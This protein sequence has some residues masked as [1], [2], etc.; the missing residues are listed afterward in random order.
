MNL[1][2]TGAAAVIIS[3]IFF[4][5]TTAVA[6]A[7]TTRPFDGAGV[8]RLSTIDGA[9]PS[10]FRQAPNEIIVRY[11]DSV[12]LA[13]RTALHKKLGSTVV[14]DFSHIGAMER[15]RI[16]RGM[17]VQ[18]A[19][20]HFV[21]SPD[22]LYA[23]PNYIV[24][25]HRIPDDPLFIYQWGL[26]NTG[27]LGGYAGADIKAATA[28]DL[29]TGSDNAVVAVIDTGV[30][31]THPDLAG[32][33]FRNLADCA[34]DG[35]DSDGNGYIDDCHGINT[36][37]GVSDPMDYIGHG[38]VI[39]GIIGAVGN[40]AT[41]ITGV[42][43]TTRILPCRFFDDSGYGTTADAI[44]CL[45]Y[46]AEMKDRGVNIVASNNSWG[47]T[48]YS[49]ALHDAIASHLERGILFITSAGNDGMNN[50]SLMPYPCSYDLPNIICVAMTD[51]YD[52]LSVDSNF[53]KGVVHLAA[54]GVDI[55]SA[56]PGENYAILTGTSAAVPFVSGVA[57]LIR[58]Y[59]PGLD[60]RGV[61]NR[62][63]AGGDARTSLAAT[64]VTG[65]RLNANGALTCS[66]ST[67]LR[68]L[69]PIESIL[70]TG[71]YPIELSALHINCAHPN[72][73]VHVSISPTGETVTL[74]DNGRD[75]D[76]VAGDGIYSGSWQPPFSGTFTLSYPD[77]ATVTVEADTDLQ[78]GF[79]VK[80]WHSYRETSPGPGI[81]TLV[82]N[83]NGE[84][85]F[86]IFAASLGWGPLNG[87][88]GRG[89]IL[90]GWPVD[91]LEMP[92]AAAGE[93]SA[94]DPGNEIVISI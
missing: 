92:F 33:M 87:W 37:N 93:L 19:V 38:T 58:G 54:P 41:G 20:S 89:N 49:M 8:R 3:V 76:L 40:N 86:Q 66:N 22:V 6:E 29:A 34:I 7:P 68:K 73:E 21:K 47:G 27:S 13:A 30:D 82:A 85:G 45:D 17:L 44:E 53:G 31:Y 26:H 56:Y 1:R 32:N 63:L 52:R 9:T 75:N 77:G 91:T 83:I 81:N 71:A 10:P 16:P 67:V 88:D 72:G 55:V 2:C 43:W 69:K 51:M 12:P 64:T 50:D 62:I 15:V 48:A 80:A 5:A 61:K 28:W 79:P 39:A 74:R 84:P 46:V 24:N 42:N 65:S 35:F 4:I 18:H 36:V 57:G 25:L 59:F 70:T 23:E 90:P 11:R 60:W 94:A 14:R 78:E